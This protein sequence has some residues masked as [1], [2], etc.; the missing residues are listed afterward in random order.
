MEDIPAGLK[1]KADRW[2][3]ANIEAF[4]QAEALGWRPQDGETQ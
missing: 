2:Y 1:E 4:A 3:A